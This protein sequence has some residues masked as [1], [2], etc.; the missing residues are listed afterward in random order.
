MQLIFCLLRRFD[1]LQDALQLGVTIFRILFM[2]DCFDWFFACCRLLILVINLL[3]FDSHRLCIGSA[4]WLSFRPLI[5][6]CAKGSYF[7]ATWKRSSLLKLLLWLFVVKFVETLFVVNKEPIASVQTIVSLR[8]DIIH[9]WMRHVL[10]SLDIWYITWHLFIRFSKS[11]TCSISHFLPWLCGFRL[12]F[13]HIS[14]CIVTSMSERERV[15][16]YP[17]ARHKISA[18][19][20]EKEIWNSLTYIVPGLHFILY[21]LNFFGVQI[22][23][24]V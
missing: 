20:K 24:Q 15:N 6:S 14:R 4:C 19:M 5:V 7:L 22:W 9:G 12:L 21:N 3:F 23:I 16:W 11:T 18:E 8:S 10:L 13:W 1:T 2:G 17:L